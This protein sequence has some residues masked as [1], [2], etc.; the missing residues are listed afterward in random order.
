MN[1]IIS[2]FRMIIPKRIQFGF[3]SLSWTW[4]FGMLSIAF[5]TAI[6]G[7]GN[8]V[9]RLGENEIPP[10]ILLWMRFGI[11]SILMIP[12]ILHTRLSPRIWLIG[13]GTGA[14]LGLSVLAQGFAMM[15]VSVDEVAFITAL[16]VVFTP[17]LV[18]LLHKK[19]P[20]KLVW[21]AIILSL[22][23]ATLLIGKLSLNLQFGVL[24]AL[25]AAIGIS[26]QIIGTSMLANNIS[27]LQLTSIQS[28]G[29]G[30]TMTLAV[31]FQ[32]LFQPAVFKGVFHW[33]LIQWV[34]IGYLVIFATI[35][36]CFLQSWGQARISA[37]EAA[38]AF[39]MEPVWTA[40]FA[41]VILFEKMTMI[42]VI[43]AV[44]IISSLT[45]VSKPTLK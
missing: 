4:F 36:A 43:G 9:I 28:I 41:W 23:G 18:S 24:F 37:T 20:S 34:W 22:A 26:G 13:L 12:A 16:Y 17:L 11:A 5:V 42:Q 38:L 7:Y 44:L 31:F 19:R 33:S 32:S 15:T 21:V 45:I 6:W 2:A 39:N 29:A 10:G 8:V 40:I 27:S 3:L 1:S 14:L 35:I 25:I 30:V